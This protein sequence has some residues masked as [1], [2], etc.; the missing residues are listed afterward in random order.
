MIKDYDTFEEWKRKGKLVAQRRGH[1]R[2]VDGDL[3][4]RDWNVFL[5][6]SPTWLQEKFSTHYYMEWS[7]ETGHQG[8]M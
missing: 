1:T 7:D 8:W 6:N 2:S 3:I 5:W 4:P